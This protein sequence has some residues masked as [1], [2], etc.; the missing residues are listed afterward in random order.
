MIYLESFS[1]AS[2]DYEDSYL[3]DIHE[4]CFDSYYPFRVLSQRFIEKL[5]FAPV[6]VFYGGNGSGKT[7]AL[8]IIAEKL[9]LKRDSLYNR[10]NFYEDYLSRC[11]AETRRTVPEHS[12]IITSD[13]VFDYMLDVRALNEGIDGKRAELFEQ[14]LSDKYSDFRLES[15]DDYDK[16]KNIN[17]ARR[18]SKSRYIRTRLMDN[19]KEN[20]NGESA[21]MYFTQK[22]EENALYLL[23][24]PENSLSPERQQELSE[25]IY[26][27]ARFF[28]C[29]I[30]M[31]THSPFL[32]SMK[33]ARIYDFDDGGKTKEWTELSNVRAY[34]DFFKKHENEF[35]M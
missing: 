24:E 35:N 32:L 25:F 33:G 17:L 10:S 15:L 16:L 23:D 20:S 5:E 14:W 7:T 22:I 12:R 1:F 2:E 18:K 9:S 3:M 31:A 21:F 13:D 27:C 4:T 28:G 6:T 34:F 29:Q 11:K 8:N 26:N 19:V 30:I